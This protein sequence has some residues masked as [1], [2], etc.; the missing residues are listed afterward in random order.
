LTPEDEE[1]EV[2]PPPRHSSVR[3]ESV[4]PSTAISPPPVGAPSPAFSRGSSLDRDREMSTGLDGTTKILRIKRLVRGAQ[5]MDFQR[6][7]H[8]VLNI[9]R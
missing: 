1:P 4:A 6:S 7:E 5:S 2:K 9:G 8:N 3:K